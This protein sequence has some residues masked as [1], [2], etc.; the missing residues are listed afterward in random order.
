MTRRQDSPTC[1]TGPALPGSDPRLGRGLAAGDIDNDGRVDL[2]LVA[3]NAPMAL[4]HN[5]TANP[6]H[7][8]VITLEGTSSNR[9][10]IGARVA[11]TAAGKTQIAAQFGGGSY[12]SAS[13]HRLH[14]GLGSA[15]V[16]DRVEVTWPSG[17]RDTY[18]DMAADAGYR[19]RE[20]DSEPKPIAGFAPGLRTTPS[21]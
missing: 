9:D 1:R 14:F 10:G 19:L 21:N 3:E 16:A 8:L 5:Q 4:F 20:Q 7:F 6:H 17:G 12:L 13:D 11:V 15:V 18:R 2:L